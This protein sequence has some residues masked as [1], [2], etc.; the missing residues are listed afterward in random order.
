MRFWNEF[1]CFIMT[2][3]YCT[4]CFVLS[5]LYFLQLCEVTTDLFNK[6][7]SCSLSYILS[8][9]FEIIINRG[10]DTKWTNEWS[11]L[12][13]K[14]IM[15]WWKPLGNYQIHSHNNYLYLM[16]E[17]FIQSLDSDLQDVQRFVDRSWFP[18]WVS[19]SV[20]HRR[21]LTCYKPSECTEK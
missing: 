13:N 1:D 20:L 5:F 2:S 18:A 21:S 19:W 3:V 14:F 16:T 15:K 6:G 4:V 9:E 11:H 10:D 8:F 12:E 17:K 7:S